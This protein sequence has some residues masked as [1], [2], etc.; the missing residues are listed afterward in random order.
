MIQRLKTVFKEHICVKMIKM[1]KFYVY[2]TIKK[3][4]FKK[5]LRVG[6]NDYTGYE[7]TVTEK[8]K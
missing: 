7:R 2:A 6:M 1:I 3:Y 4:F 8:K 5:G